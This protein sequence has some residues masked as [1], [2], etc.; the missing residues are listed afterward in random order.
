[1]G[2]LH[3]EG[4]SGLAEGQYIYKGQYICRESTLTGDSVLE[5]EQYMIRRDSISRVTVVR[6]HYVSEC[7]IVIPKYYYWWSCHRY[8]IVKLVL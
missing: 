1:M 7:S 6:T 2:T 8:N 3:A 5:G 4:N